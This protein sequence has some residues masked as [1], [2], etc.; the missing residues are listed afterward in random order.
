MARSHGFQRQ[1]RSPRRSVQWAFGPNAT[2]VALT[3]TGPVTWTNGVVTSLE[4][5]IVRIRGMILVT[6]TSATAAGDGFSGAMGIGIAGT[7][8]FVAGSASLP[9]PVTESEWDGWMWHTFFQVQAVT[10]TISDGANAVGASLRIPVDTKA[11]RKFSDAQ[12]LFGMIEVTELGTAVAE[13][14]ADTRMLAKR[15]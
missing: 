12:T 5:T 13:V 6:L 1:T 14:Q 9:T 2:N 4:T 15:G 8:A 11:M 7:P 10:A 3:A